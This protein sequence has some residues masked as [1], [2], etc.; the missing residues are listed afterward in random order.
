[1]LFIG[2]LLQNRL[3]LLPLLLPFQVSLLSFELVFFDLLQF[4]YDLGVVL[5]LQELLA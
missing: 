4:F 5:G 3:L 1:M 2:S